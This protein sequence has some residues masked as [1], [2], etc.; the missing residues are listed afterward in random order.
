MGNCCTTDTTIPDELR[1]RNT[2]ESRS[3]DQLQQP[4]MKGTGGERAEVQPNRSNSV[5]SS[6]SK[7][8]KKKKHKKGVVELQK[9]T[10]LQHIMQMS[11]PELTE[12]WNEIDVDNV[13]EINIEAELEK[14]FMTLIEHYVRDVTGKTTLESKYNHRIQ[15][16]S[17]ELRESFETILQNY[18]YKEGDYMTKHF[19]LTHLQQ[20]IAT[21]NPGTLCRFP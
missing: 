11:T 8:K 14:L 16:L 4:L 7:K 12:V 6:L 20:Y 5:S 13:N 9:P 10:I 2:E 18:Q 3:A 17:K 19:F 1:Q 15:L 21:P